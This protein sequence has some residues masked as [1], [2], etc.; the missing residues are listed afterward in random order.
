[1]HDRVGL[2]TRTEGPAQVDM[3][4]LPGCERIH[5][6]EV[7]DIDRHAA[8]RLADAEIVEGME[9][10]RSEPMPAPISPSADAFSSMIEGSLAQA[11]A[12]RRA[13]NASARPHRPRVNPS[14]RFPQMFEGTFSAARHQASLEI[15]QLR[16]QRQQ[17]LSVRLLQRL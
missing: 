15:D 1:M 12:P 17:R 8:R 5:Q 4:D 14:V 3:G 10:I 7:V 6:P 9:R 13:A 11:R 2:P 16:Q